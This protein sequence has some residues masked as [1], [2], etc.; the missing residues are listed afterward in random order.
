MT[1]RTIRLTA[2]VE[3]ANGTLTTEPVFAPTLEAAKAEIEEFAAEMGWVV[4]CWND[5]FEINQSDFGTTDVN[6]INL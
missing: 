2:K 4:A 6:Q 3:T 1:T 5:A